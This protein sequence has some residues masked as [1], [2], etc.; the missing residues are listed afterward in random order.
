M[1]DSEVK[2]PPAL[3]P[4]VVVDPPGPSA[5]LDAL[6]PS[7]AG[8][9]PLRGR[10]LGCRWPGAPQQRSRVL[11]LLLAGKV[12]LGLAAGVVARGFVSPAQVA[13]RAKPPPPSLITARVRFG[14]L[15]VL[16]TLRANVTNGHPVEISP[17]G[18]LNGSLPVVTSANVA[19]GQHVRDG[20][21]V[22]TVAERPVFVFSG[23]IPAFRTMSLGTLGPDVA[24]LQAGLESAG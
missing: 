11:P 8:V 3:E 13:A 6:L 5:E 14:V 24:Q 19:V 4:D 7:P 9:S 23:T 12:A 2:L 10:M 15:P 22:I 21:L 17:P 16:V 18:D 1:T 20:R